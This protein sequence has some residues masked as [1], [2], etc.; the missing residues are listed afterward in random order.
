M[1]KELCPGIVSRNV[2]KW[3]RINI[4]RPLPLLLLLILNANIEDQCCGIEKMRRCTLRAGGIFFKGE[5]KP[6]SYEYHD[7]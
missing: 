4:T 1:G 2:R 7:K 3:G 6:V 5:N